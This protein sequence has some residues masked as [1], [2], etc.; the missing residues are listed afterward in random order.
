MKLNKKILGYILIL[1]G[2]AI[3]LFGFGS[4]SYNNLMQN[5]SYESFKNIN[6]SKDLTNENKKIESYNDDIK[7]GE[8]DYIDPFNNLNYTTENIYYNTDEVFGYLLIPSLDIKQEIRLGASYKNLA[9]GVAQI[10]G[11]SIPAGGIGTRSVLAGHRGWYR[12]VMFL[13]L[14]ELQAGDRVLIDRGSEVLTYEVKNKEVI[15]AWEWEKLAANPMKDELT[16]L[17]CHPFAPPRPKRLLINC[18]RVIEEK[19]DPKVEVQEE[20]K[21]PASFYIFNIV[22]VVLSLAFI[23]TFIKLI[24]YIRKN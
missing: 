17:T 12:D 10:D 6:E 22:T 3:P 1:I 14:D 24:K 19:A 13:Y 9:K 2:I 8:L 20:H 18:E 11:T 4:I 23:F 15:Q 21:L 7:M 5:I 16:L